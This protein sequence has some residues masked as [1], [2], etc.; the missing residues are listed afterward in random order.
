MSKL[1]EMKTAIL[2]DGVIDAAE[3][4]QIREVIFEDGKVDREEADFLFEL[5]DAVSGKENAAEWDEVFIDG[6]T[7]HVLGDEVTPGVVDAEEAAYIIEKVSGDEQLD[8]LEQRLLR[9][10]QANATSLDVTL[11]NFIE[12][13]MGQA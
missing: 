7:A 2:A 9:N 13:H 12:R 1:L 11:T 6:V 5:N 10:I 3:A 8:V 4:A